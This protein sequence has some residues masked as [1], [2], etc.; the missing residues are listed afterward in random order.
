MS[1]AKAMKQLVS[2]AAV[3]TGGAA[4]FGAY[5]FYTGNEKFYETCLIPLTHRFDPETAHNIA[6]MAAKYNLLP[7]SNF[8]D[9]EFLHS[10]V[11]GLQFKN[12]V[13][14]AAGFDKQGEAI[15]GLH[16]LGFGFVEIGSVTPLPQPGNPKP[17]VFRLPE[18]SAIINRYGFNSE[19]HEAVL[20]RLHVLKQK[21]TNC[22]IGVNL[23][24]NKTSS[25]P[26][27]DY[28]DGIMKF[29]AVAD[30]LVINI[31][32]P[33][34]P[35]LRDWQ[36]SSQLQKLLTAMVSAKNNLP[37]STKPPILVKLAPDLTAQERKD[38]A[39]VIL[40]KECKVDGL[41]ISNTTIARPED[42]QSLASEEA[43]G[44]SGKPLANTSTEL[45]KDMY[46]LTK[47][48][49]P[50]IGVGGIFTG[51]DAYEKIRAGASL[52][53]FY[54]AYVYHGPPRISKIKEELSNLLRADGFSNIS[55]AVGKDVRV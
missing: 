45:I 47:G 7:P 16:S 42:L 1:R 27:K 18:D 36:N 22:I 25:D 20:E 43:G 30:Y 44:L 31:S 50:I 15:S 11:W 38:I 33:N 24:K 26:V 5:N 54:T 23:G 9:S 52:V 29:G 39:N 49:V 46:A 32:S 4:V 48:K 2:M 55:E 13:G 41:I 35:G 19:G 53:Q 34:T 51:E 14:M 10:K 37:L 21:G 12:P 3:C 17:R 40:R 8:K 6:V 28:V